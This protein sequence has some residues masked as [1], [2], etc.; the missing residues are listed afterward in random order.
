MTLRLVLPEVVPR[1][2]DD[3]QVDAVSMLRWLPLQS[4]KRLRIHIGTP[5]PEVVQVSASMRARG[6]SSAHVPSLVHQCAATGGR[7]HTLGIAEHLRHAVRRVYSASASGS[8]CRP[9]PRS[10]SSRWRSDTS[11]CKNGVVTSYG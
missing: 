10:R 8:S 11:R 2:V 7:E 9:A 6:Q 4:L 1:H 3:V 5:Q